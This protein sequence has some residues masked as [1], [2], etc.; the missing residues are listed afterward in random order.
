MSSAYFYLY[1]AY[2]SIL[3]IYFKLSLKY[4]NF[5]AYGTYWTVSNYADATKMSLFGGKYS[6]T[7]VTFY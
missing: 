1:T 5:I 4:F 2:T 7:L 3:A 6:A